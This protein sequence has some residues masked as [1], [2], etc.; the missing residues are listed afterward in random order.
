MWR[1]WACCAYSEAK[2]ARTS[3]AISFLPA[4]MSSAEQRTSLRLSGLNVPTPLDTSANDGGAERHVGAKAKSSHGDGT[5]PDDGRAR[6]SPR[7]AGGGI[8]SPLA[9]HSF[10][11][12][13]VAPPAPAPAPALAPAPF[14]AA[15]SGKQKQRVRLCAS[16]ALS[17]A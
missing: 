16:L 2:R 11:F 7:S 9:S 6:K 4:Q 8:A 15:V 12:S 13:A 1:G 17:S 14:S 10:A 5:S 3:P